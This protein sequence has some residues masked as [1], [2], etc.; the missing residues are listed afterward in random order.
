VEDFHL[1]APTW[2]RI[3]DGFALWPDIMYLGGVDV[4][5]T[6]NLVQRGSVNLSGRSGIHLAGT[7]NTVRQVTVEDQGWNWT[8]N[9][10]IDLTGADQALVENCTIRRTAGGACTRRSTPAPSTT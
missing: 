5:G 7:G 1:W 10:G 9:E 3:V 8:N 4:S 6:G 2:I